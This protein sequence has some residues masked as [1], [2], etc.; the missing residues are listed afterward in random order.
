MR[1]WRITRK[2]WCWCVVACGTFT[3]CCVLPRSSDQQPLLFDAIVAALRSASDERD[4]CVW[5]MDM[6]CIIQ[7][8]LTASAKQPNDAAVVQN[9]VMRLRM[10]FTVVVVR[11]GFDRLASGEDGDDW[12]LTLFP[13]SLL[14]V[15]TQLDVWRENETRVCGCGHLRFEH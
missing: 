7:A 10:F 11:A 8:N 14:H 6:L 12:R 3:K 1:P 9:V 4:A 15:C 13:E 5:A 2:Y